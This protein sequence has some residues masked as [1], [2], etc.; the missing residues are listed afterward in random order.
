MR[1]S[2]WDDEHVA[3]LTQLWSEGLSAAKVAEAINRQFGTDYSRNAVVGK[4][5]RLGLTGNR[6][7]TTAAASKLHAA[8]KRAA[9]QQGGKH[10]PRFTF[11]RHEPAYIFPA[12][13]P[14]RRSMRGAPPKPACPPITIL[15]L[16]DN[17][18]CKWPLERDE[19]GE[20]L[21]CG[22]PVTAADPRRRYCD[23][24]RWCESN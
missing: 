3:L 13:P 17:C 12:A 4:L 11:A 1:G 21:Y 19:Y 5:D 10:A 14:P 23:H 18:T 9:R 7:G 8:Q 16:R 2:F 20:R 6:K 15:D 22:G 24:H